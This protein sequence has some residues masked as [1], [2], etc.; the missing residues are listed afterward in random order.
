MKK[1]ITFALLTLLVAA[2]GFAQS[3]TAPDLQ[4][5]LLDVDALGNFSE[6]DFSCVYT[7]VS[8]KP[9]EEK[10]VTQ[11][12]MFRRD[13]QD[14]FV[15]L[16]LQPQVQRGQ[17]Y[18]KADDNVWF[19]DPESRKF[20]KSTMRDNV[21]DSDAQNSDFSN[22]SLAEDYDVVRWSEETLGKFPVYVLELKAKH[23]DVSYDKIKIWVRTDISIVLKEEDFSVSN[24]LMRTAIYP[25]YTIVDGRYLPAS[26]LIVDQLND[27]ERTQFSMKEATTAKIPDYVFTKAYLER[28]NN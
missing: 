1:I 10:S 18:L 26:A 5:I 19:Y 12:R 15:L 7:I 6:K 23:N 4:Q 3:G 16:I 28:V 9:G 21:Q 24:R 17:G 14:Q 2:S 11:A 22:N 20:E 27:G 8:E 25:R 13:D